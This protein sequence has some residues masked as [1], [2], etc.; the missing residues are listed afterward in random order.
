ME[1]SDQKK[2]KEK[3]KSG[4]KR[5]KIMK[6]HEPE[7]KKEKKK[8]SK[9]ECEGHFGQ[10]ILAS[11]SSQFSLHFGEKI[12]WWARRENTW[13]PLFIFLPLYP[14]KHITNFFFFP[15]FFLKLS[16]H[17]ISLSNKHILRRMKN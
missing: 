17:P 12:F 5:K 15:I 3:E 14:T 7:T 16:I 1:E 8:V 13:T 9:E 6:Q 10:F 11:F 2:K 4:M